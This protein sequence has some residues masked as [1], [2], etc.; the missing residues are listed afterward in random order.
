MSLILQEDSD[1]DGWTNADETACGNDPNDGSDTPEDEDGDGTCNGLD[2]DFVGSGESGVLDAEAMALH[3]ELYE[4]ARNHTVISYSSAWDALRETD[5][6]PSNSSNVTLIYTRRSHSGNDTCGD[7]NTCTGQSWNREHLWPQSHGDFGTTMNNVAGTDLHALRPADNTV[8][9]ARSDKDFDN[10]T[11]QHSECTD[12]NYSE[13]AWEPPDEV[14]GDV[15]RSIF[16]MDV[17]YNGYGNEPNL[18]LVN[19][20]SST[21][22]GNGTLGVLC[23]L[24]AWHTSDPVDAAEQARNGV[25]E[26]YQNNRN[27]FVDG[28]GYVQAIWG[29]FCGYPDALECMPG[30][31]FSFSEG[32]CEAAEAGYYAAAN[33]TSQTPC[34]PGTWQNQSGQA[35]CI[36]ADAGY[37]AAG[38][39]STFQTTC[40]PGNYQPSTGQTS[41]IEAA[42]GHFVLY[43]NSTS[44]TECPSGTYQPN[45][46][47]SYCLDAGAGYY[48]GSN[49][50][51]SQTPCA[52]G[53]W[54]NQS[55]QASCD[56]A[57]AGHYVGT[58]ASTDQTP[59][60]EGDYQSQTGQSSCLT[61]DPGYHTGVLDAAEGQYPCYLGTYAP[62]SGTSV[63][64]LDADV[65]YYVDSNASASQTACA[66]GTYQWDRGMES[67]DDADA[68][69]YV[70]G[71]ASTSQEACAAGTYQNQT[72]QSGCIDASVGYYVDASGA[73]DQ[74][75]CPE[76][77]TTLGVG[78]PDVMYCL[79]DTDGDSTPDLI[80]DDD[81]GDESPDDSDAFPLNSTEWDDTDSDGVGN[82]AD[83]D[84]DGDGFPDAVEEACFSDSLDPVS[85]PSDYDVDGTCDELDEDDDGDG[86]NDSVDA[87]PVDAS[88]SRD[89]DDDGIGDNADEDD[90]GDGIADSED[91]FPLDATEATDTDGDG[92]G[93]NLDADD[94]GDGAS[95]AEEEDCGSDGRDSSSLPSDSDSDGMC[96]ATDSDDDNDG[97]SD[98]IDRFPLDPTE[99][100]DS[101]EDGTGDNSD[102]D[103]DDDGWTDTSEAECLTNPYSSSSVPA[104][105]DEDGVCDHLEIL[106]GPED[107]GWGL[108]G[109]G[110][111]AALSMLALA[112]LARR[113]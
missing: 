87:F 52:P 79:Q 67:C 81:D 18:T 77:T 35:S 25:V 62:G 3:S 28:P 69:Y 40:L 13:D 76:N 80:D 44:Q 47:Q 64:C 68:G 110:L 19:N 50:S 48:V 95:D 1:G 65:G 21:S 4:G 41:C 36:D 74:T 105:A 2:P 9:S 37:Y 71:T 24:Y 59:C 61:A 8:N 51:I 49:A 15:A 38:N 82:N 10:A 11:V 94:D 20:Y 33:A 78:S 17:R 98:A 86:V 96:D 55:G 39:A 34:A 43:Y 14:K 26:S 107:S 93:D 102:E 85:T 72:G 57:D 23:T 73:V 42:A 27:P 29:E 100:M 103:D 7:G 12:C 91:V 89:A 6:G 30:H 90:D 53:T 108:P 92:T 111:V 22:I 106:A 63:D 46:G 84:D 112:A 104:D 99:S 70:S 75:P 66:A 45:T 31:Y 54:Q 88:E 32:T 56:D 109:F 16:Y 113:D 101:D 83:L 58:N 60:G 5:E 97:T